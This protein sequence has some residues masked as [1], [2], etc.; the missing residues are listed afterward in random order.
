MDNSAEKIKESLIKMASLTEENFKL[1]CD[2]K[3]QKD[4]VFQIE[5]QINKFHTQIDDECFKFLALMKPLASDL[6]LII[7]IMKINADLERIADQ[8][9]NIKRS[10][11]LLDKFPQDLVN[12]A[13][14]VEAQIKDSI[15]AFINVDRRL[16]IDVIQRDQHV[17]EMNKKLLRSYI[18]HIKNNNMDFDEAFGV[19]RIAKNLERIGDHC[20]NIAEDVIFLDTGEDIRHTRLNDNFTKDK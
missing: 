13:Q 5:D 15:D 17:D 1:A 18:N 8:A 19:I 6:R 3:T 2:V 7:S 9:V 12:M 4:Q 11:K 10:Q 14:E 20:T 16:S